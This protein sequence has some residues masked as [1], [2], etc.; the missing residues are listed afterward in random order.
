MENIVYNELIARGFNVDVGIIEHNVRNSDG[1]QQTKHLEVDFVCNRGA[2][3]T[4]SNLRFPF[5]HEKKWRK[6]KRLWI[7]STIHSKK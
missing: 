3:A 7:E 6:S 4:T 5:L 1:K 2:T